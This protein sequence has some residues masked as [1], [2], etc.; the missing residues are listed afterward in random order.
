MNT[1]LIKLNVNG[2]TMN[3]PCNPTGP[4]PGCCAMNWA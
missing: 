3:W 1:T 2:R 4:C